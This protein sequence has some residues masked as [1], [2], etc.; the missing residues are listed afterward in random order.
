MLMTVIFLLMTVPCWAQ[1]EPSST[2]RSRN[3]DQPYIALVNEYVT[4]LKSDWSYEET[5]HA[6]VKIQTQEGKD[7]GQWPIYYNKSRDTITDIQAHVETP[8]GHQYPAKNVQDAAV[9]E[10]FP[11]YSDLR[12]KVVTLPQVD[13]GCIIDVTVKSTT[14][15]KEISNQFWAEVL[16]PS[17]PTEHASHAFIFPDDK[18]IPY[19]VYKIAYKPTIEKTAGQAP[20][21]PSGQVKYTF[22][23]DETDPIPDK[24]DLMPPL[25]EVLGGIYLSSI[26]D[27]KVVADWYRGLIHKNAVSNVDM[28]LKAVELTKDKTTQKDK[29]RAILEFLQ[30]NF[31][32]VPLNFADNMVNLHPTNEIFKSHYGD[33]KDLGL[34]AKEMLKIADI[35]ANICLFSGEFTGNPQNGLPSPS[36]FDHVVLQVN[37]DSQNYFVDP[38]LKGFDFGQQPASYDH[39]TVMIIDETG[40]KFDHWPTGSPDDHSLSSKADIAVNN[41]GSANFQVHVKLPLEGSQSFKQSWVTSSP[42]DKE[43]FFKNLEQN[44]ARGGKLVERKVSGVEN[45]YGLVEF[46]LKYESPN[47]YP[48]INDMML[49]KEEDQSDMPPFTQ[50]SRQYPIFVSANSVIKSNNTYRIPDGFKVDFVPAN[51]SLDTDL[52]NVSVNYF[53]KDNTV[54][55]NSIYNTKRCSIVP[56]HYQ[57]VRNF[58]KELAP[59]NNQ[60]VV[61]KKTSSLEPEAKDWIKNQ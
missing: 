27:W 18:P 13:V 12:M 45:R 39:A 6:R 24:E 23:F 52:M 26:N 31:H 34:L 5:Y 11:L 17:L 54:E 30:D 55:I 4:T 2:W 25:Q 10:E 32:Y 35:D 58:R 44:F 22:S 56:E 43:K 16:P 47:A 8:D 36:V 59:K 3:A 48:I 37:L 7:L 61:L 21:G 46:D 60:Y 14:A 40:F 57:E 15:H 28:T 49:I 33:G 51:Y 41:D 50:E 53:K 1:A 20:T 29:A 42:Q 19:K 38:Q 9:Y